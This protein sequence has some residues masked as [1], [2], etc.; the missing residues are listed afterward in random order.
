MM[1]GSIGLGLVSA[2]A[3]CFGVTCKPAPN[4][5]VKSAKVA[6]LEA[7]ALKL[8]PL[9]APMGKPQPGDWL[10]KHQEFGQ[11][12]EYY[13][14]AR[15]N[16]VEGERRVLY[17]QPLGEFN[18]TERRIVALTAD[19]MGRFFG[20]AVKVQDDLPLSLVPET[21]RRT[22]PTW[23][24]KQILS[25]YVLDEVLIPRLPD[26]AVASI[27]LTTSDLWPGG[28]MNFVF[29]QASMAERVGVWSIHRNGDPTE[30]ETSFHL[31]LL[32]TMKTAA[33]ETGHMFSIPH[34]I[35]YECCM[36]GSNN[37]D[38]LDRRPVEFCPE[39]LIKLCWAT[40]VDPRRRFVELADFC[41]EQ[42]F[43][44]EQKF[45]ERSLSALPQ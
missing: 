23:D 8:Q 28:G 17:V 13:L 6:E 34:C 15:P 44:E 29:G 10:E 22:H 35:A 4:S 33:H 41:R 19:F 9:H 18:D 39:C 24:V 3:I 43:V 16:V 38:E 36:C 26:D 40:G 5:Q 32:R 42:G 14:R 21:A 20:L 45:Y 37:R 25:T 2:A 1:K 27:A 12:F 7:L 31:C 11:T 30:D